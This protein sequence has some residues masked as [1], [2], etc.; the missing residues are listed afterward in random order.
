MKLAYSFNFF[1]ARAR[2]ARPIWIEEAEIGL[3]FLKW[4]SLKQDLN[5]S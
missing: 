5:Y 3:K 1:E 2:A 4:S